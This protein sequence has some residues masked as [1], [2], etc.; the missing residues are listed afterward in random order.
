MAIKADDVRHPD[1]MVDDFD[2]DAVADGE[3]VDAETHRT[4]NLAHRAVAK[5]P[6][7]KGRYK[8]YA[9]AA[10]V[11]SSMAT[12]MAGVAIN[13]KMK[14]GMSGDRA[15]ASLT[16]A[17]IEAAVHVAARDQRYKRLLRKISR[18]RGKSEDDASSS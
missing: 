10:V 11:V 5:F 7:L 13:R 9:G 18:R 17:D 14:R 3:H 2:W 8:A 15:L 12:L 16:V 4:L 6:E 1:Q